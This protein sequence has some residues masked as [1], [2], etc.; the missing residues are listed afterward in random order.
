MADLGAIGVATSGRT[1]FYSLGTTPDAWPNVAHAR[2]ARVRTDFAPALDTAPVATVVIPVEAGARV[3]LY[4]DLA[5]HRAA[6]ADGVGATFYGLMQGSYIARRMGSA[7]T[8]QVDVTA[9]GDATVTELSGSAGP[10]VY[11][12]N[13]RL[14]FGGSPGPGARLVAYE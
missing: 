14:K 5:F 1:P 13:G 2:S 4:Q 3:A 10:S 6:L 7:Q 9:A 8:W 11:L 12:E